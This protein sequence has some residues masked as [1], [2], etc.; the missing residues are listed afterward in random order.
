MLQETDRRAYAAAVKILKRARTAAQ[1]AG[2][3]DAFTQDVA[4]LRERHRRRP[5]LIAMLD[6]AGLR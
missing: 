5:T 6:K 2:E 1:T 4:R 3:L